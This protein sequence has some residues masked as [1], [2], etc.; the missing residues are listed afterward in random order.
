MT[1]HCTRFVSVIHFCPFKSRLSGPSGAFAAGMAGS[2]GNSVSSLLKNRHAIFKLF[3]H[4][5]PLYCLCLGATLAAPWRPIPVLFA[6]VVAL[7]TPREA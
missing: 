3:I 2:A 4:T 1:S 7:V 5:A 6:S